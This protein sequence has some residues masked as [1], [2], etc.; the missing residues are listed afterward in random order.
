MMGLGFSVMLG[1]LTDNSAAVAALK[2]SAGK[3]IRTVKLSESLHED[4]ALIIAFDD[5]ALV[6]WDGG[7]SCCEH[8]Y[9]S[10]DDDLSSFVGAT[11]TDA[12][13]RDGPEL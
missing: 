8:R 1:M 9:M 4:G 12:E 13:I 10:T 11:F 3:T 2:A 6:L 5:S 7:R